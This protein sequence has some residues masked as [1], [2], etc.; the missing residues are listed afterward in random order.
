MDNADAIAREDIPLM[1]GS[2]CIA[3]KN[4]GAGACPGLLLSFAS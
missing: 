1:R 4:S 3:D 2:F